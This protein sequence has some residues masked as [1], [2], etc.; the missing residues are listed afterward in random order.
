MFNIHILDK[1]KPKMYLEKVNRG[2]LRDS[3]LCNFCL[4]TKMGIIE[5][6]TLDKHKNALSKKK[7]TS[8]SILA[9]PLSP[10]YIVSEY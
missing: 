7:N 2:V 3:V 1:M 9:L 8:S 6:P 5:A 10:D 4:D